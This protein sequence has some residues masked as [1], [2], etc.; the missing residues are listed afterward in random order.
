[1]VN[2]R[3]QLYN[4]VRWQVYEQLY[5]QVDWLVDWQV[6]RQ[7]CEQVYWNIREPLN[8]YIQEVLHEEYT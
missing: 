4:Q 7:V 2:I 3:E 8:N 5:C 6:Y 1:M